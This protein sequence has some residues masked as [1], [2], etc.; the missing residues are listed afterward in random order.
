[1]KFTVNWLKDF[2][3]TDADTDAIAVALTDVGLEVEGIEKPGA[4]F[5][6]FKAAKILSAEKHPDADR[7][8]VLMVDTG[9]GA[10]I[11]VVCGAPNAK[12]DMMGIFAPVGAYI[13]GLDL[14]LKKGNIRGVESCGMMV[15]EREMMLSDEHTGIIEL[16]QNTPIG[17]HMADIFGLDDDVIEINLTPNRPDC[18]GIN[19]IA[20]DLAAAGIGT[21]TPVA[22]KAIEGHFPSP[23][24]LSIDEASGCREFLGYYIKGVK[25]GPSP[26]WLQAR[27]KAIGLR[28]I[29]TLVDITNYMTIGQNR[30][31][32]VYDADKLMGNIH[33]RP[34]KEGESFDALNDKHYVLTK[35]MTVITDDR[36]VIGLAGIVGGTT[37]AADENTQN[38]FLECAFFDAK[39][40]A[41][42][43][44]ALQVN[45]D[46][47]YRFERGVDPDWLKAGL[48]IAANMITELCG[49]E[50]SALTSAGQP[51]Q[52]QRDYEFSP[53]RTQ[54]LGG[55]EIAP[56]TQREILEKLGFKVEVGAN[57]WRVTPP[58]WRPD[59]HGSADLVEEVLRIYGYDK[60]PAVSMTKTI[61]QDSALGADL[62][63]RQDV[64]RML[65]TRGLKEAITWS[66]MERD[67]AKIFELEANKDARPAL[68]LT[69]PISTA[70][71]SMRPSILPNLLVAAQ[72]NADR[73][74][75]GAALFEIGPVFYGVEPNAQSFVASGVRHLFMGQKHWNDAQA[76]RAVNAYDAK[77]DALSIIELCGLNPDKVQITLEAPDYYHPGRSAAIKI[78][79]NVIGYFGELHPRALE[80]LD[81]KGPA[82]GFEVFL[83][84]IPLSKKQGSARPLLQPSAFQP[85]KRDFAFLADAHIQADSLIKAAL[86]A[87]KALITD[88]DIFDVYAG[89]NMEPGKKSVAISV[90]LQPQTAT[91]TDADIEATSQK[92]VSAITEKTGATLRK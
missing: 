78:G 60:I 33:V 34:A 22:P 67:K 50:V 4:K 79:Q 24:T 8:Q 76:H 89:K 37:T 66:F 64:R 83:E 75:G 54:Q 35:G 47:R 36:G 49:G 21:Y 23:I 43:G 61:G 27:L 48:D 74:F 28:P 85:V 46:A 16:P 63:R 10:P 58:S 91:L 69:N 19:G 55:V 3:N 39:D 62:K 13:P 92:I 5:A 12:A 2:L 72:N 56:D 6:P 29:S 15:S 80:A 38:V 11:Q 65:A 57:A 41:M 73:G 88:V 26:D 45:S 31:L 68:T 87:D 20:R 40:I 86:G 77:A 32:H 44:R 81:V 1:M 18:A 52:W 9:E 53:A 51:A 82:V 71:D 59:I 90:T 30:P 42:T 70:L 84:R 17:T 14:V 25:N 7:L